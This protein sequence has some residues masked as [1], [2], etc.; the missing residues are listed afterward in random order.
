MVPKRVLL[1]GL[2]NYTLPQTRHSIGLLLLDYLASQLNLTWS[3]NESTHAYLTQPTTV[4]VDSSQSLNPST[5]KEKKRKNKENKANIIN[6][7]TI[8]QDEDNV[9]QSVNLPSANDLPL[10]SDSSRSPSLL[11]LSSRLLNAQTISSTSTSISTLTLKLK[12][13]EPKPGFVPLK[14]T[15]MKPLLFMNVSGKSV[16]KAS[17]E[18]GFS[19]SNIIIIHDDMQ[20]ELGKLSIKNGGS[21]NG[22]NGIKSVIDHL[23]TDEF[24]RLR[25]GI[26]R[27]PSEID[28]RSHDIVSNFVLS[29]IPPDEMEIYNNDVFP[30]C[31]DELFKTSINLG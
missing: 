4:Y 8:A 19:H 29:R 24:L 2:G 14:L 15:L 13:L 10:L 9:I 22:H 31:K 25:I 28:D 27:P 17:R 11:Q 30:R 16:S 7:D 26:G 1:V 18:L 6:S 23:K 20:R 12:N 5:K 21:A 3:K